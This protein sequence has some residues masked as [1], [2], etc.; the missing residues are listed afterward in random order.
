MHKKFLIS[1]FIGILAISACDDM[2]MQEQMIVGGLV[3]ATVG[4][5]TADA[6]NADQN[7]TIIAA[8]VGATA[9]VLVARNEATDECAYARGDGT[10]YTR[11]CD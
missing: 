1:A 9:G 4:V 11:L 8:L 5:I 6:L 2:T 3:G 7:W 10:Y